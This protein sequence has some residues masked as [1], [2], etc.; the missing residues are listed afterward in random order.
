MPVHRREANVRDF[1]QMEK[2]LHDPL[3]DIVRTNLVHTWA[4]EVGLERIHERMK[5]LGRDRPLFAGAENPVQNLFPAE[6]LAPPILLDDEKRR[7]LHRFIRR[8]AAMTL[9][10]LAPPPDRLSLLGG[11]RIDHLI[12]E[13][14]ARRTLHTRSPTET[15]VGSPCPTSSRRSAPDS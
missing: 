5:L 8:E 2:R 1:V 13:V 3:A 15:T 14:A 12:L 4:K 10:T 7:G 9:E 11:A 6:R